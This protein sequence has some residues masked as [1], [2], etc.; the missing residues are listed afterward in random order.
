MPQHELQEMIRLD[1]LPQPIDES[2][3]VLCVLAKRWL[4]V[5]HPHDFL[6]EGLLHPLFLQ[7]SQVDS[8]NELLIFAMSGV[9][10]QSA[11]IMRV[12]APRFRELLHVFTQGQ[13]A[14]I[15]LLESL[16][17]FPQ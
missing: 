11:L 14:K 10:P 8:Q 17:H 15:E 3:S 7:V 12:N 1:V 13:S 6:F 4:R 5:E 16:E 9:E 2:Q